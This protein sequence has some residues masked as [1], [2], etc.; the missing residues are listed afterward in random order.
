MIFLD[1]SA[2]YAWTDRGDPQHEAAKARLK[3]I[4]EDTETLVTHNYVLVEATALIQ[5][6][7]GLTVARAFAL[8][9]V[10]FD[11]EWVDAALHSEALDRWKRGRRELSLVD[12]VSFL[13]MRQRGIRAA[14]AFDPDFEREGFQVYEG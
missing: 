2:I 9:A 10:A 6:R 14:F 5:R 7:L 4:L 1:T 13:V 8:D 11:I 3:A 12:E